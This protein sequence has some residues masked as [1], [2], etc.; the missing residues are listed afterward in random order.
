[1]KVYRGYKTKTDFDFNKN[2][3]WFNTNPND[4]AYNNNGGTVVEYE[5]DE[6]LM[7]PVQKR[8]FNILDM[9]DSLYFPNDPLIQEFLKMGYNCYSLQWQNYGYPD[10]SICLFDK[11]LLSSPK[12]VTNGEIFVMQHYLCRVVDND[13]FSDATFA[14]ASLYKKW[15]SLKTGIPRD[16]D[17]FFA[18]V[19]D[20]IFFHASKE[21]FEKHVAN[22]FLKNVFED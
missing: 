21:D 2:H 6:N 8:D 16:D 7:R 17:F 20:E 15:K 19:E 4:A 12:L 1:M 10:P 18:Y 9:Y 13:R 22:L 11:T 14:P 3:V 5:L